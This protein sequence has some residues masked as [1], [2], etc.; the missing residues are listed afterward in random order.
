MDLAH[1]G[2]TKARVSA[3]KQELMAWSLHLRGKHLDFTGGVCGTSGTIPS[4]RT[5]CNNG[6]ILCA[7]QYG[8]CW[9]R[10]VT[11]HLTYR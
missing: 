1:L 10:V 9:T 5:F 6:S 11:E 2:T 7:V 3:V 4:D 8:V